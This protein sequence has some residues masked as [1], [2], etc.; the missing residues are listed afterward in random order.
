[1]AAKLARSIAVVTFTA[2]LTLPLVAVTQP[3]KP[4]LPVASSVQEP[5]PQIISAILVQLKLALQYDKE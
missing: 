4:A 1:M 3:A 2:I 5:H